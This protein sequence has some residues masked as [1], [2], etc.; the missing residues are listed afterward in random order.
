[1]AEWKWCT[2]DQCKKK[3]NPHHS[4]HSDCFKC[5]YRADRNWPIHKHIPMEKSQRGGRP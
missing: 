2:L 5:R 3:K 4:L 1:M